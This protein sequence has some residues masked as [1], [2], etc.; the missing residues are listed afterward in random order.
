MSKSDAYKRIHQVRSSVTKE[1][2]DY[3]DA[4]E[5]NKRFYR[6][7]QYSDA[8]LQKHTKRGTVPYVLD[9]VTLPMNTLMGDQRDT[10]TDMVYLP[11]EASD[12]VRVEV[13]NAVKDH[14]LKRNNWIYT[15]S[16]V[17]QDGNIERMGAI[18]F[19]WSTQFKPDGEIRIFRIP[20]RQLTWD[21]NRRDFEIEKSSWVSRTRLYGKR[22]LI[23]K[24]PEF[25]KKIER[26]G[27]SADALDDLNLSTDYFK[28][29]TDSGMDAVALIEFYERVYRS[30]FFITK[31]QNEILETP[32]DSKREAEGAL[33]EFAAKESEL[34]NQIAQKSGRMLPPS[35]FS[36]MQKDYPLI[37]CTELTSDL[38]FKEE[39]TDLEFFPYETYHPF[40][41]DGYYWAMMDLYKDPQ[42]FLNKMMSMIDHQIVSSQKGLLLIDESVPQK[43]AD[44][45]IAGWNKA[46]G[47]FRVPNAQGN[48]NYIKPESFDPRLLSAMDLAIGNIEKKS[49]GA[50]LHGA[51]E[52]AGES[53]VA[54]RQ[55]IERGSASSFVVF[56]NFDRFKLSVGQKLLW[57]ISNYMTG[58][59]KVRIE[60]EK[61]T[62]MAAEEFPQWYEGGKR[63]DVGYLS[64]NTVPGNTLSDLQ[65]DTV[66]DKSRHTATKNQAILFQ[67]S[68]ILR[69][70]PQMAETLPAELL[71]QLF[72]LPVSLKRDMIESSR[73][74][75]KARAEQAKAELV[76][77]PSL[78]ASLSDIGLFAN[79][80][81]AQAQL[82]ARF[83][84]QL[85]APVAKEQ[86]K[87]IA[88]DVMKH[89]SIMKL[90]E[91]VHD[92]KT[93]VQI[94]QVLDKGDS[95]RE[96][97][98]AGE[99]KK[100]QGGKQ[101]E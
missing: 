88:F 73:E 29:I 77:P 40:W 75:A 81:L 91:T 2:R 20:P 85:S 53:G 60:G 84:I 63:G 4:A 54:V 98:S 78:S 49:G 58:P 19:E 101:G 47:A 74:T 18:G 42:R 93:L 5:E 59:Q 14:V 56:D 64:I 48:F 96:K 39:D 3:W 82:A 27:L 83:G 6:L 33:M 55:R 86:D 15:E 79:D 52:S 16:D 9:Y 100:A 51:K 66:V 65:A 45:V 22:D 71:I 36:L 92:E 70:S 69:A 87:K 32:Y 8:Q 57:Y 97:I 24:Y 13:G 11:V 17:F 62:A 37:R 50:N 7:L 25:K 35:M 1:F 34:I 95:D 28:E 46:G 90:K 26:M 30:K 31:N 89:K 21:T 38:V 12:E 61:T 68:D 94:A 80:P 23:A 99:R 43:T 41:D 76:K 44:S 10:R 72:D 67:L